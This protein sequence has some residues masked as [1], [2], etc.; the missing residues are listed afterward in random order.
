MPSQI[1]VLHNSETL[2]SKHY[3]LEINDTI[4][5]FGLLVK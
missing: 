5:Q 3:G 2:F 4:N 1:Q